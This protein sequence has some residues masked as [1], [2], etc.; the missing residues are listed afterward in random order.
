MPRL[1]QGPNTLIGTKKRVDGLALTATDQDWSHGTGA[2]VEG[3]AID[4]L[5][6]AT[7]R[8]VACESLAGEGVPTLRSRC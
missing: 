7:G 1:L 2:P 6:A 4:L 8:A 5:M 3:R